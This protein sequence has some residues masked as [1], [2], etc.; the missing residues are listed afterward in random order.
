MRLR[1]FAEVV[2]AHEPFGA[3]VARE[4]FLA[5]VRPQ[6]TLEFVGPRE[7]FTAERPGTRERPFAGMP[8]QV[9]LQVGRFRVGFAAAGHVTDVHAARGGRRA[10]HAPGARHTRRRGRRRFHP[11]RFLAVR[12]IAMQTRRETFRFGGCRCPRRFGR[13]R[14]AHGVPGVQGR[15]VPARHPLRRRRRLHSVVSPRRRRRKT[16]LRLDAQHAA[17]YGRGVNVRGRSFGR[18]RRGGGGGGGVL[19]VL[20][21]AVGVGDVRAGSCRRET[22]LQARGAG[23]VRL[24]VV[25]VVDVVVV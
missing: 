21:R 14:G 19:R 5:G 22:L 6:V 7:P 10:R 1:V 13:W 24:L 15:A 20:R 9:R 3:G 8:A 2:A 18:G 11:I 25:L 17:R 23:D 4:P 12:A 16:Q